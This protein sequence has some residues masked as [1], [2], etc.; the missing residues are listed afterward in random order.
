M[1]LSC[2]LKNNLRR[3][4]WRVDLRNEKKNIVSILNLSTIIAQCFDKSNDH[5]KSIFGSFF[6]QLPKN[7]KEATW[8]LKMAV[9]PLVS[10]EMFNPTKWWMNVNLYTCKDNLI[11]GCGKGDIKMKF[12]ILAWFLIKSYKH[13][14]LK[15]TTIYI[16]NIIMWKSNCN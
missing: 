3:L 12:Q 2:L 6:I 5:Q 9:L 16:M 15:L 10:E 7:K 8:W 13:M 1:V 4:F 11:L 14:D